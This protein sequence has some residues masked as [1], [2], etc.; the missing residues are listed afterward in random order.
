MQRDSVAIAQ[1]ALKVKRAIHV[2]AILLSASAEFESA[3]SPAGNGL[4]KLPSISEGDQRVR[5]SD[6]YRPQ[7]YDQT[8]GHHN[9]MSP[10]IFMAII[11]FIAFCLVARQIS[12]TKPL[13]AYMPA[14]TWHQ[15]TCDR[16]QSLKK[17][18]KT[19]LHSSCDACYND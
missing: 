19:T 8:L 18:C 12:N 5:A 7:A 3:Y 11:N 9:G 14:S 1:W 13:P 16:C 17:I 4:L 15:I 2:P 10:V 6:W